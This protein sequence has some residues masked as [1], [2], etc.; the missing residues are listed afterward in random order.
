MNDDDLIKRVNDIRTNIRNLK[1]TQIIGGDSW[2]VYRQYI[3]MPLASGPQP[4]SSKPTYLVEFTPDIDGP[5]VAKAYY[6]TDDRISYARDLAPD[7]NY[8]GRWFCPR[9]YFV[10]WGIMVYSTKKGN[11]T[12]TLVP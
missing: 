1:T 5:F 10:P 7:P 6:T 12:V 11:A 4:S 8:F 2:V 9:G 3:P